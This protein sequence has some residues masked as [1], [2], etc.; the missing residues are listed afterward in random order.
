MDTI[1]PQAVGTDPSRPEV[2]RSMPELFVAREPSGTFALWQEGCRTITEADPDTTMRLLSE[3]L[4]DEEVFATRLVLANQLRQWFRKGSD[5]AEMIYGDVSHYLRELWWIASGQLAA[6]LERGIVNR[7]QLAR[8]TLHPEG[9]EMAKRLMTGGPEAFERE[10][11]VDVARK[12][13]ETWV[14]LSAEAD[15]G[16]LFEFAA[17]QFVAAWKPEADWDQDPKRS[18]IIVADNPVDA[19]RLAVERWLIPIAMVAVTPAGLAEANNDSGICRVAGDV[20]RTVS[21]K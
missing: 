2:R 16:R 6:A 21:T 20:A 11:S 3:L 9:L 17:G 4:L 7:E 14:W 18:E 8:L 12:Q 10:L 19:G 15:A 5:S 1:E 13:T